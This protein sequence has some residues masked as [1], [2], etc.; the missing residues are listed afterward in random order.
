MDQEIEDEKEDNDLED[1]KNE[2]RSLLVI[3][4]SLVGIS[5][6]VILGV[7]IFFPF[8]SSN[9]PAIIVEKQNNSPPSPALEENGYITSLNQGNIS[10]NTIPNEEEFF[11]EISPEGISTPLAT[12]PQ[13]PESSITPPQKETTKTNNSV[14]AK[15]EKPEEP[16]KT[17]AKPEEKKKEVSPTPVAEKPKTSEPAK[18]V[19]KPTPLK[20]VFWI[21]IGS[22]SDEKL[23]NNAMEKLKIEGFESQK[24][25]FNS[26]DK[27]LNR[28]RMGPY[29]TKA[30]ANKFLKWI[31]EGKDFQESYIV[32]SKA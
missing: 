7:F 15:V 19:E 29:E 20:N 13:G 18:T 11:L 26:G 21:Q 24:F 23:A 14:P 3:L 27:V 31:Q 9:E 6:V 12:L 22:Y 17:I 5:L 30:E 1:I 16:N 8:N 25:K 28:V 2:Q 4:G 10:S 32:E